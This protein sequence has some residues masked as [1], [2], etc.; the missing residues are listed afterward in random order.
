MVI[1][2][3]EEIAYELRAAEGAIWTGTRLVIGICAFA[4]ASLAF[5]YFTCARQITKTSGALRNHR[6]HRY[7]CGDLRGYR[8][9]CPPRYLQQ[10]PTA[11]RPFG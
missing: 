1:E 10:Q 2:T 11:E 9:D 6:S 5:A 3:P 4:L 7:R 8:G